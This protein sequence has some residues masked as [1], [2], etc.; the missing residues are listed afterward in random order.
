MAQ[1]IG[2]Y[3]CKIDSKGRMRMPSGLLNQLEQSA[4]YTFVLN[5]GFEGCITL[6]PYE[7][8][9]K[10]EERMNDLNYYNEK[11]R[12]LLRLLYRGAQKVETDSS[13]RILLQKRLIKHADIKSEVTLTCYND[14]VEIW[15]SEKYENMLDGDFDDFSALANEIMGGDHEA[16]VDENMGMRAPGSGGGR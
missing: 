5:R 11:E 13:E 10:M 15:D 7:V 8:W 9:L 16:R 2:E 4:P 14:K 12:K 1:L 3:D 6:Y